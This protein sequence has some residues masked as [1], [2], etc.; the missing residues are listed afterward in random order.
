MR[1]N[2]ILGCVTMAVCMALQC[3]VAGTL[4]RFLYV[5][6]K[7][8]VFRPTPVVT[9]AVLVGVMLVMLAGNLL[10]MTLWAV[11]FL[12]CGEFPSFGTAF[13][14]SFVNFTT[15]GYG[16]IVM[17]PARRLLGPLEAANGTLMFGLTTAFLF[18]VISALTR[19][20]W[21]RRTGQDADSDGS[22]P[23]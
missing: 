5:L 9:S 6:E 21:E 20:M 12:A 14:H 16:D 2:L 15:L 22:P 11:L 7:K 18:W 17:S 1:G 4:L 23:Q 3:F 19:R 10:Q 13:Y 8:R